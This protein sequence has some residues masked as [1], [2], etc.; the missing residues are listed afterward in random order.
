MYYSM[1]FTTRSS[2]FASFRFLW[3]YVKRFFHALS[4]L[5]NTHSFHGYHDPC[6]ADMHIPSL[7]SSLY[8]KTPRLVVLRN[9]RDECAI[10]TP[11][12]F[13]NHFLETVDHPYR[14]RKARRRRPCPNILEGWVGR[15]VGTPGYGIQMR[16]EGGEKQQGAARLGPSQDDIACDVW[17]FQKLDSFD[18]VG[19]SIMVSLLNYYGYLSANG[20]RIAS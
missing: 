3:G 14:C 17:I 4:F 5:R 13:M 12:L 10:I 6:K 20:F 9:T 7:F 2:A 15:W 8:C 19:R 11:Y 18:L 16:S 1:I